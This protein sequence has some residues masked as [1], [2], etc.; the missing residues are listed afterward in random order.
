MS[1]KPVLF[2]LGILISIMSI[3]MVLPMLADMYFGN[4]DWKI[5]FV[6]IVI[7]SFFGGA[8]V[9]SNN[10]SDLSINTRQ[11]FMLIFLSWLGM[12]TFAAIPFRLSELEMSITDA[13]FEAMS[14]ITTTGSTVIDGLDYAPPGILLWR[15]ILQWL[16]GIGIILMAMSVLP[17]LNIGG[18]QIFKT[19]MTESEKVLP[20]TAQLASSIGLIYLILTILC[21]V[22]YLLSGMETFDALAHAMTTI[23]TGGFS[24]FDSSF[25]HF[26]SNIWPQVVAVVFMTIGALPFVLYLKAV[27]GSL[28]PLIRDTQVRWFMALTALCILLVCA[29]QILYR[30]IYYAEAL[31]QTIF[32]I[33]SVITGTGFA[34]SDYNSW[35]AFPVAI[36]FFIML[37]GGCAGSTSCGIKV[38]R[39]QVLFAVMAAQI[40][41]LMYPHGVFIPHYNGR[42]IPPDVPLSVMA[43][44]FMYMLF[45]AIIAVALSIAGLDFVEAMSGAISAV[46][47]VGPALGALGPV[48]NFKELSDPAKWILSIGMLLGR[49]EIFTLLVILSPRFWKE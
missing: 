41:R 34:N 21:L 40:K 48:E 17:F 12:A 39:F 15:A 43:F 38:F 44:F 46:S 18:M 8:L 47:N 11:A 37:V 25:A 27:R 4:D 5:F 24:T 33:V 28:R 22:C 31:R 2:V 7:T 16:G 20:R 35:G 3:S 23:S 29:Y 13:F 10:T 36:F 14:G 26:R 42:T 30:D 1:F 9:I 19:E 6:S 49:L 32:S 45:C